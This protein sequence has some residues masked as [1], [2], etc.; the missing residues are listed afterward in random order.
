MRYKYIF[1]ICLLLLWSPIDCGAQ[2]SS[3]HS[4]YLG[5]YTDGA[6][7]VVYFEE[8]EYGMTLR[9]ALWTATQLLKQT[10]PDEFTVVDRT[11]RG[12][13]FHRDGRGLVTGVTI[14]GME[15]EGLKLNRAER[16]LLPIELLLSGKGRRAAQAY[17]T[18]DSGEPRHIL[19]AAERVLNRFPTR[20]AT[21][22]ALL[23]TAAPRFSGN[24]TLHTLLGFAYV[25][26]G[27]RQA[28]LRSF[29]RAHQLDPANKDAVSGLAR[30]R[31][32]TAAETRRDQPWNVPFSLSA[33]FT[34]PT[35]AEIRA[36]TA[37][38][39]TRDL[40]VR[41]VAEVATGRIKFEED[42][43]IVRIVSHLV[44][45]RKHYGAIIAPADGGASCCPVVVETKGVSWNYFHLDLA[46]LDSP[47]FM[48][49]ARQRFIYVV[50]SFRGEVL[51]FN[52]VDYQSEGDRTNAW[53]GATD[54]AIA[55]LNVALKT[56]PAAD[57][58]RVCVFGRSRGGTVALLMGERDP[59]VRC[60]VEW[61][62]PTDWFSLMG[63][64]GWTQQELFAE[65]LRTRAGPSET[66]GQLVEHFLL[67]AVHGE[68]NLNE[69]RHRMLASSPLYFSQRLPRVQLHYGIEDPFVPVRNGIQ[70]ATRLKLRTSIKGDPRE[71]SSSLQTFAS[72]HPVNTSRSESFFY[73]GQGHD[74]DRQVAPARSREFLID[75]L[76]DHRK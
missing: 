4:E 56:T 43:F 42:E 68:E 34:K 61:S 72:R 38:W 19:E 21:V 35:A 65:G 62:G 9:P 63:T 70:L 20:A 75:V 32:L 36:V 27:N 5:R 59:R 13:S 44:H 25:E 49:D 47:V 12:A 55:L 2:T 16:E 58:K 48:K 22:I 3:R 57:A 50:P 24:A 40:S 69:V 74:T 54:D 71:T 76:L 33:V 51:H 46:N 18:R 66:G 17:L 7:Y 1:L 41:Q 52:G 31:A 15:G 39:Q 29:R 73:P 26:A 8:T 37:D 30:L 11:E 6:D 23:S 45:G 53:D 28:A 67:K 64:E 10:G 60:V 14:R